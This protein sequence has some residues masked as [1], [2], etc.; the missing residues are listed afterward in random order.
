MEPRELLFWQKQAAER[1]KT[2]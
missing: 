1:Y 2:K